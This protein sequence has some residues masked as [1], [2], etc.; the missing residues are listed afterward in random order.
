[1]PKTT[2]ALIPAALQVDRGLSLSLGRQIYEQLRMRIAEGTLRPGTRLPST[3][4]LARELRVS[5]KSVI[6]AF[7]FLAAK[8]LVEQRAGAGTRVAADVAPS[9]TGRAPLRDR[10]SGK[11]DRIERIATD[12]TA[13]AGGPFSPGVAAVDLLP[14]RAWRKLLARRWREASPS[15]LSHPDGGGERSLCEAIAAHVGVCRGI[16]CDPRQIIVVA[17]A[18]QAVDLTARVLIE[19]GDR[20]CVEDPGY[21]GPRA[22]YAAAGATLIGIPVDEDGMDVAHGEAACPH[23]RLIY[24]TPAHQYPTGAV[25]STERRAALMSWAARAGAFVVEDDFGGEFSYRD[26][27]DAPL[28]T[29][30]GNENV[31]YVGTFSQ[32]LAPMLRAGFAIVPHDLVEAFIVGRRISGY[33]IPAI[34]QATLA[35]FISGGQFARHLR[36]LRAAY[37]ERQTALIRGLAG[38]P[39][40]TAVKGML[41]GTHL[42]AHLAPGIDDLAASRAAARLGVEAPTLRAH[43]LAAPCPRALMLGYGS[44]P[45]EMIGRGVELLG[46]ALDDARYCRRTDSK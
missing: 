42:V 46:R 17:G 23:P 4:D 24:V 38:I 28:Y 13:G 18:R 7:D 35:D 31:I 30:Y 21:I 11:P 14:F 34:E 1:M 15:Q 27:F 32:S 19:P 33:G 25:L 39:A 12:V 5:R 3:R 41:A 45:A 6:A 26:H 22:A 9:A 29:N 20:V 2:T 43:A 16:R 44:T 10:S 37:R 8:G 40:V 36:V